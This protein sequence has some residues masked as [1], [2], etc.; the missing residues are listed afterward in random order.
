MADECIFPVSFLFL[1]QGAFLIPFMLALILCGMPLF[2]MEAAM[3]QF[4]G[5]SPVQSWSVCP[6]VKGERLFI[7]YA[8]PLL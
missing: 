3:G 5:R 1:F 6:L 8:C 7:I 4:T 2:F